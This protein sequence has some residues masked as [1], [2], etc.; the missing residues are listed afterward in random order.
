MDQV[1][2]RR[3][4]DGIGTEPFDGEGVSTGKTIVI[5]NGILKSYL[6]N[7]YSALKDGVKSTGNASRGYSGTPA[8]GPTNMYVIPG[9]KINIK[10]KYLCVTRLMGLHTINPISGDFSVG[11]IGQLFE[12][13][14]KVRSVR[15]I[16]IAGNLVNLLQKIETV[17]SDLRFFGSIGAPS[18]LISELSISG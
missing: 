9:K 4:K 10:T 14:E 13:G 17:G 15:G 5:E 18:I 8:I 2:P 3:S 6:Y 12:N 16:T 11:A 7:T 1:F